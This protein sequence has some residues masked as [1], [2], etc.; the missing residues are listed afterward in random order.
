MT[1]PENLDAIIRDTP[2]PHVAIRTIGKALTLVRTNAKLL[3]LMRSHARLAEMSDVSQAELMQR[4]KANHVHLILDVRSPRE[5][6]NGHVPGAINIPHDML[7]SRLV[8]LG[9]HIN[10]DVVLYCGSGGRVV[11][12]ANILRSAGFSRLLH[13]DGDMNG[14]RSNGGLPIAK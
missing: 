10:K 12:A 5:Y 7:D 9:S 3:F 2:F 6:K 8:E 13:L 4:I 1:Y 14:W 11:I